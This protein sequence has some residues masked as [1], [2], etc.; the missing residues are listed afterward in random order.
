MKADATLRLRSG[1]ASLV[2]GG[3][4]HDLFGHTMD[5]PTPPAKVSLRIVGDTQSQTIAA[6][7]SSAAPIQ[8]IYCSPISSSSA[9]VSGASPSGA[10]VL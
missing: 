4:A 10:A 6:S 1:I 3:T 9:A 2:A 8:T 7:G 5:A